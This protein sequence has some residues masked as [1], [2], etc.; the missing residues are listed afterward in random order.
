MRMPK[1]VPKSFTHD[2]MSPTDQEHRVADRLGGKRV[3]GSGASMYSKGDVRDVPSF[4]GTF[5]VECK[6]TEKASIGVKWSWLKKITNEAFAKECYPALSIEIQGGEDDPVVDRDW[7][8][9]P[10]RV[11]EKMKG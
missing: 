2:D 11:F 8:M 1:F 4:V 6:K 10:M 7:I 5:L 3:C 9:V